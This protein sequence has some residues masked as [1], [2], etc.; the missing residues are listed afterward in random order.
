[1]W[2][3]RSWMDAATLTLDAQAVIAM[4]LMKIAA[5]GSEGGIECGRMAVEKIDAM[6][7]AQTAAALALAAGR[8]LAE[9]ADLAI[10]PIKRRVLANRA[11]LAGQ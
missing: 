9:A 3:V 11:R 2:F 7:E 1:M 6:S 5:G 4:R 10:A 8:S